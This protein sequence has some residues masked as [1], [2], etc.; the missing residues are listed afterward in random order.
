M[1]LTRY[2]R[3]SIR[4]TVNDSFFFFDVNQLRFEKDGLGRDFYII[5]EYELGVLSEFE[6]SPTRCVEFGLRG[7]YLYKDSRGNLKIIEKDKVYLL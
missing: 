2:T 3:V 1:V 4:P 5:Q 7:D 6:Q